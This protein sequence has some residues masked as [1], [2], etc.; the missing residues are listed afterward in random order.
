MMIS[1][2]A[3]LTSVSQARVGLMSGRAVQACSLSGS[4]EL[5]IWKSR[6]D[7]ESADSRD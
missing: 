1:M 3:G 4:G 2:R 6:A 5:I 7:Y